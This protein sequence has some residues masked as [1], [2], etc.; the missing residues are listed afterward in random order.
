M[1]MHKYNGLWG[2]IFQLSLL[3][4]SLPM[5]AL[6]NKIR[7]VNPMVL[8]ATSDSHNHIVHFFLL[9]TCSCLRRLMGSLLSAYKYVF[10][11]STIHSAQ[12][13]GSTALLHRPYL[14]SCTTVAVLFGAGDHTA[15][16]R[17][18]SSMMCINS[19]LFHFIFTLSH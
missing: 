8:S 2:Y 4:L 16:H 7:L 18:E 15:G 3:L 10:A 17:G 1:N 19:F 6:A 14:A 12:V 9:F 5:D 11:N 13:I